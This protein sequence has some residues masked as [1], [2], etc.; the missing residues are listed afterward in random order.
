MSRNRIIGTIALV[1]AVACFVAAAMGAS[2]AF[3]GVGAALVVLG[4]L[5]FSRARSDR[6]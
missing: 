1:A 2:T 6:T 4:G 3:Y 5:F